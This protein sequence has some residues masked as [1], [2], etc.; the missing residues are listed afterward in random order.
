MTF[1]FLKF[2]RTKHCHLCLL[3]G[4][5]WLSWES[6]CWVWVASCNSSVLS[7]LK[8]WTVS[9]RMATWFFRDEFS[10]CSKVFSFVSLERAF[11]AADGCKDMVSGT[12]CAGRT[13]NGMQRNTDNL[14]GSWRLVL[15]KDQ[16]QSINC[17]TEVFKPLSVSVELQR[18]LI[19]FEV[20][21][22]GSLSFILKDSRSTTVSFDT[23][24]SAC[25]VKVSFSMRCA[26]LSPIFKTKTTQCLCSG[27][28]KYS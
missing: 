2:C 1:C 26:R 13:V 6:S 14:F 21:L 4:T 16:W 25:R 19:H 15:I 22:S 18:H 9:I 11:A 27:K 28:I 7:L 5:V 8:S 12:A 23:G 24:P 10:S 3:S 17:L 20:N